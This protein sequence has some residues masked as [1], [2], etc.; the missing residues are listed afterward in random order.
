MGVIM[1]NIWLT[2]DTQSLKKIHRVWKIKMAQ[3]LEFSKGT[4]GFEKF[5]K[6][7]VKIRNAEAEGS[8]PFGSTIWK[9]A[10]SLIF[11]RFGG[12]LI[13]L[14]HWIYVLIDTLLTLFDVAPRL[15]SG[16]KTSS[17]Q[18]LIVKIAGT[19]RSGF[20]QFSWIRWCPSGWPDSPEPQWSSGF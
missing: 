17:G 12:F 10:V 8:N 4:K 1:I 11:Q 2:K 5:E 15:H 20:R 14:F 9:T 19:G 18:I 7:K 16:C 3:T 13:L 6:E